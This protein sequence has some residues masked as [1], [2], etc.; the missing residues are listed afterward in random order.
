MNSKVAAVWRKE[1]KSFWFSPV[2]YIVL[3]VFLVIMTW[4]FFRQ[5]FIGNDA[6]LTG[7]FG[8]LPFAFAFVLPSL[9]MRQW[10]EERSSGTVE[11][12][13]TKPVREWDA[14]LGKFLASSTFLLIALLGTLPLT[15]TVSFLSQNGLDNGAV[16]LSYLGA[17]LLGMSYLAIGA[18]VSSLTSNQIVAF[19][20]SFAFI[21][22]LIL[23]GEAVVTF[24][25]RGFFVPVLEY[26]GLNRH[27]VSMA[28]GV[29]DTRD[30]LYYL[31]VIFLFLYLT[32]RAVESRKW[33]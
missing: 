17:L 12:L 8:M 15:I 20:L 1:F 4:F 31:S 22:A 14:V 10:A 2:A 11:L 21:F 25:T 7:F 9:T 24:F 16:A 26:L 23:V 28:R 30:L 3:V 19:I 33:S 18:W 27:Y 13:M 32:T 29:L 5:F 6:N